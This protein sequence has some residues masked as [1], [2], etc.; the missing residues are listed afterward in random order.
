MLSITIIVKIILILLFNSSE[1]S[2]NN[3]TTIIND[4]NNSIDDIKNKYFLIRHDIFSPENSASTNYDIY[5][6][7]LIAISIKL[8]ASRDEIF[9][10]ILNQ[11]VD[12]IFLDKV[13]K[14]K[15]KS[16]S[17]NNSIS[18]LYS[19]NKYYNIPHKRQVSS[20][21]NYKSQIKRLITFENLLNDTEK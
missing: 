9:E 6:D 1:A 18:V 7:S 15:V 17:L 13:S 12:Q 21:A 14:I 3:I 4:M 8:R 5:S 20:F 16:E 11:D 2:A 10:K 19:I